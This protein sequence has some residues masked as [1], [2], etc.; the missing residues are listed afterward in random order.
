MRVSD[1][2]LTRLEAVLD[3]SG[4]VTSFATQYLSKHSPLPDHFSVNSETVDEFK[5]YLAERQIQPGVSEWSQERAWITNRLKEE[6]VTQA[7][8]VA[9]GDEV[10]AQVDPQIQAA[11]KTMQEGFNLASARQ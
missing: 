5:V 1:G 9:K 7:Q 8:G 10:H 4:A 2:P 3:A 6:L 11:L